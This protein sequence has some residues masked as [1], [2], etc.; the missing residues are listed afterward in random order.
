MYFIRQSSLFNFR[1]S[2]RNNSNYC[3]KGINKLFFLMETRQLI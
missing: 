2:I 1:E 3:L